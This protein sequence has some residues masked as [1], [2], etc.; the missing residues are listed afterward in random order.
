MN[1]ALSRSEGKVKALQTGSMQSVNS[2]L[3]STRNAAEFATNAA[4][5]AADRVHQEVAALRLQRAVKD[6]AARQ[7]LVEVRTQ[8]RRQQRHLSE[9]TIQA[10]LYKEQLE[11]LLAEKKP[12]PRQ[13]QQLIE[14]VKGLEGRVRDLEVSGK[15]NRSVHAVVAHSVRSLDGRLAK[16]LMIMDRTKGHRNLEENE[17]E[18]VSESKKIKR[19]RKTAEE[20]ESKFRVELDARVLTQQVRRTARTERHVAVLGARLG[21]E[22]QSRAEVSEKAL[23][24]LKESF[25]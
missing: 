18:F 2:G 24:V 25:S 14:G 22:A 21:A 4:E 6:D 15:A 7:K 3:S 8:Q 1:E 13:L 10:E 11:H 5:E 17:A 9:A 23:F 20:Q 12:R 16:A 19:M